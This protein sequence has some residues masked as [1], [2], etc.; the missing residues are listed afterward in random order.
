MIIVL[1][2]RHWEA[3]NFNGL[4]EELSATYSVERT[5]RYRHL[6]MQVLHDIT[7]IIIIVPKNYLLTAITTF[8]LLPQRNQSYTFCVHGWT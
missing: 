7:N 6:Q 5:G 8:H 3:C 2:I 4:L 1:P